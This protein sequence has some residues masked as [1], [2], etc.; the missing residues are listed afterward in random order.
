MTARARRGIARFVALVVAL[1]VAPMVLGTA[2]TDLPT[3]ETEAVT[4][5][6][7]WVEAPAYFFIGEIMEVAVEARTPDGSR[8]VDPP[9]VWASGPGFAE[10]D[11]YRPAVVLLGA[12]SGRARIR[13]ME[14]G[15]LKIRAGISPHQTRFVRDTLSFEAERV[16]G[17]S[18]LR[19]EGVGDDTAFHAIGVRAEALPVTVLD[20]HGQPLE[21]RSM[22]IDRQGDEAIRADLA[23]GALWIRTASVGTD[24]V[25]VSHRD[26]VGSCADTLV[27]T[28][29]Q[30]PAAVVAWDALPTARALGDTLRLR[31]GVLDSAGTT[32]PGVPV[33]WSAVDP[34]DSTIL[35][36]VDPAAGRV[37]A[38][39]N[40]TT[41]LVVTYGE[42]ADTAA[43]TVEQA[44]DSVAVTMPADTLAVGDV[45]TATVTGVFDARGHPVPDAWITYGWATTLD[46]Y[47]ASVQGTGDQVTVTAEHE[48]STS[49]SLSVESCG[50]LLECVTHRR[51]HS[52]WVTPPP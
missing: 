40:G 3:A 24:T 43:V 20:R 41:D 2:C 22:R 18:E 23:D 27:V 39:G 5:Q 45:D 30:V 42:L 51:T 4:V 25:V 7:S 11:D 48:G 14:P 36:V 12:D 6:L 19:I 31:A 34:A 35:Q 1:V 32:I 13:A 15:S 44:V 9:I 21:R 52:I 38:R 26:C 28:V 46:G 29:D 33:T 8:L 47:V 50:P 49:L 16:Y 37:L 10:P 17:I